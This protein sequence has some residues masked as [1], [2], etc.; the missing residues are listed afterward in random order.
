M[1]FLE[2]LLRTSGRV[3]TET[4]LQSHDILTI[5]R[6]RKRQYKHHQDFEK[7]FKTFINFNTKN[8]IIVYL[9]SVVTVNE[10]THFKNAINLYHKE[11]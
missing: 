2:I 5:Y 10:K 7:I 1:W 8:A 4:S 9:V 3:T 6:Q 11:I